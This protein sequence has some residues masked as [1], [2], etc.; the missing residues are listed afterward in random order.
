MSSSEKNNN[1][2]GGKQ[3]MIDGTLFLSKKSSN[4]DLVF[5]DTL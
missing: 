4:L 2:I 3:A 5:L 1:S